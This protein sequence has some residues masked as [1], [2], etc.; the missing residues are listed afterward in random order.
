MVFSNTFKE[1]K[2]YLEKFLLLGNIIFTK[3]GILLV[4]LL[5]AE[6]NKFS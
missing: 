5:V 1:M 2:D 3:F 4:Q 6:L